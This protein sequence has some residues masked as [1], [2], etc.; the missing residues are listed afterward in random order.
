MRRRT[1]PPGN[2]WPACGADAAPYF[3]IFNPVLQGRKFD[4]DGRYVRRFVPELAQLPDTLLHAPWEADATTLARF[5]VMLGA[6]YPRPL[7]D[8]SAGRGRALAA[9]AN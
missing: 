5:G 6:S 9:Y 2:G 8:L 4:P 3:R 7:V 1:A